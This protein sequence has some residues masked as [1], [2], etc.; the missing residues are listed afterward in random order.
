[1][2]DQVNSLINQNYDNSLIMVEDGG[3]SDN[4]QMFIKYTLDEGKKD[5]AFIKNT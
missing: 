2:K 3:S 5:I 1:M 4:S